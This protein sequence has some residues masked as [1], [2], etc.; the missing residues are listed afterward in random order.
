[1]G[2]VE[3]RQHIIET[4]GK[5]FY[6]NGYNSTGVNEII[7][8]TGVAKATLYNH[9]ISKEAICIAHLEFRH[10]EFITTLKNLL[11]SKELGKRQLLGIFD[12]LLENYRTPGFCG[13]LGIKIYGELGHESTN[14]KSV[15]QQQKKDLL[16][17]L[18]GLVRRNF[19]NI[20]NAEVE[21]VSAGIYLLYE[22]AISESHIHQNDW[23]IHLSK[24]MAVSLFD[25]L[26]IKYKSPSY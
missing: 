21:K 22:A 17:F 19:I 11:D 18:A 13:C 7:A 8:K 16:L 2:R 3:I 12:F 24:K 14:I 20:S 15:V 1:M 23:P 5:L 6:T 25:G 4:A 26:E 9:F 10:A